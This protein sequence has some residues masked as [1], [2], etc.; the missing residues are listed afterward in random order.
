MIFLLGMVFFIFTS[1]AS[2]L[3]VLNRDPFCLPHLVTKAA[4]DQHF[5]LQG[6]VR[7]GNRY[8]A[9]LRHGKESSVVFIDDTCD[10]Y[11]VTDVTLNQICLVQGAKRI[12]LKLE[13]EV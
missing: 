5:V 7:Q 6:I 3:E 1:F 9:L 13:Q 4:Q 2:A 10:G 8:G 11:M 12:V